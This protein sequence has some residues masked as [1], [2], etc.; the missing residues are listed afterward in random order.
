MK[1]LEIQVIVF[2]IMLTRSSVRIC[3]PIRYTSGIVLYD[4]MLYIYI[5]CL[6]SIHLIINLVCSLVVVSGTK[7]YFQNNTWKKQR[8]FPFPLET[9]N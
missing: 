2:M 1:E 3:N 5:T 6:S 9:N 4:S 7:H 8:Y